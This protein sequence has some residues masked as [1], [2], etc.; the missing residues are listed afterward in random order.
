MRFTA[1]LSQALPWTVTV[2][3]ESGAAVASG[4]GIGRQGRLDLGRPGAT[5]GRYTY[6]IDVPGARSVREPIGGA[7]PLELTA[8]AVKPGV[9][10]P[11][12]DGVADTAELRLTVTTS[13]TLDLWLLNAAGARV[14]T[15]YAGRATRARPEHASLGRD[16]RGSA[17]VVPDGRYTVVAEA[18]I[19]TERVVPPRERHGR[20]HARASRRCAPAPSRRTAT[21]GASVANVSWQLTRPATVRLRILRG[22]RTVGTLVSGRDAAAGPHRSDVTVGRELRRSPRRRRALHGRARGHDVA[23]DAPAHAGR[24]ARHRRAQGDGSDR[25]TARSAR[26]VR[27]LLG[28]R[29]RHASRSRSAGGRF[30]SAARK[31]RVELWRRTRPAFVTVVREGRGRERRCEQARSRS[32]QV[33]ARASD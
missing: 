31:G 17:N 18:S 5:R 2:F 19:G 33:A 32:A 28:E 14:A 7:V 8:L 29:A 25:A 15:I 21:A 3:S 23:R 4:S 1:R 24:R 20:S 16:A 13:A 12:G 11:N 9:F 6:A 26:D 30:A 10:T 22:S 27:P